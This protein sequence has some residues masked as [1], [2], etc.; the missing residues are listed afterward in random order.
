MVALILVALIVL[1]TQLSQLAELISMRPK[2]DACAPSAA[3]SAHDRSWCQR[4]HLFVCAC[5]VGVARRYRKP[6]KHKAGVR[7]SLLVGEGLLDHEL[8]SDFTME[9]HHPDRR[10]QVRGLGWEE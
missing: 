10:S 9:F 1:P 4:R 6:V 2:Y 7:H 5:A 3:G 8:L